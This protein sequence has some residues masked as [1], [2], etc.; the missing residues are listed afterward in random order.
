[1]IHV[2]NLVT[3]SVNALYALGAT[4]LRND[5]LWHVIGFAMGGHELSKRVDQ[6][7]HEDDYHDY[8]S[9]LFGGGERTGL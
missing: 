4:W 1:M 2:Q 7:M 5:N 8:G 9:S 6:I 3:S